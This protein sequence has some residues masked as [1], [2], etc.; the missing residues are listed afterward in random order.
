MSSITMS[1]PGR[2]GR[3]PGRWI[4]RLWLGRCAA[5]SD[6]RLNQ[7]TRIP[8]S[9]TSWASASPKWLLPVPEGR[10]WRGS[11]LGRPIPGYRACWAGGGMEESACA[12]TRRSSRRAVRRPCG[13][14]RVR[15]RRGRGPLRRAGSEDFG[16]VPALG[17][18]GGAH[19]GGG[20]AEVGQPHPPEQADQLVRD[21][22]RD[23]RDSAE[24]GGGYGACPPSGA[25]GRSAAA[26]AAGG[27]G[28]GGGEVPAVGAFGSSSCSAR[29]ARA[30]SAAV[31]AVMASSWAWCCSREGV[32]FAGGVG[33]TRSASA[34][35][36]VSAWRARLISV[37]AWR[38]VSAAS[39]RSRAQRAVSAWAAA[40]L[41]G[42]PGPAMAVIC[43]GVAAGL[44]ELG[45]AAGCGAAAAWRRPGRRRG[46]RGRRPGPR[47]GHGSRLRPR[48]RGPAAVTAAASARRRMASASAIWART[49]AGSRLAACSRAARISTAAWRI[50]VSRAA[51][52]SRG[53]PRGRRPGPGRGRRCGSGGRSRRRRTAGLGRGP[54]RA[55]CPRSQAACRWPPRRAG[56]CPAGGLLVMTV[57]SG[58]SRHLFFSFLIRGERKEKQ[59]RR[60][61]G[62][63]RVPGP[64]GGRACEERGYLRKSP[65][66]SRPRSRHAAAS[67]RCSL[68]GQ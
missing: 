29:S 23:P 56:A 40:D 61:I 3:W 16:G 55:G 39:S 47:R 9:M 48:R 5:V 51:S 4:R 7:L 32:A 65:R 37:S 25:P 54:G 33:G 13:G 46:R 63:T 22:R 6:S 38:A 11:R 60:V 14:S 36:S 58:V 64:P 26:V 8:L 43:A 62:G 45:R 12:R 34:R 41:L 10:R 1:S 21:R 50:R 53:C 31:S 24:G 27:C 2:S 19:F 35:A 67:T 57:P 68:R 28:E 66:P 20:G 52:G 59:R 44:L 18:G 17:P 30:R 42:C 15:P 49:R